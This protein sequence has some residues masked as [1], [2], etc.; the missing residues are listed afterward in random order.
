MPAQQPRLSM[1]DAG[2]WLFYVT[3]ACSRRLWMLILCS[4]GGCGRRVARRQSR[5]HHAHH[6]RNAA[7]HSGFY[8]DG[9]VYSLYK[10][11]INGFVPS[12]SSSAKE[13]ARF[14]HSAPVLY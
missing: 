3:A 12:A 5:R 2:G 1:M 7:Q 4:V 14:S 8:I 9:S 13:T 6:P 11:H 10:F